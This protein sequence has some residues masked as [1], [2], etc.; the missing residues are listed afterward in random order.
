V[1][2][3]PEDWRIGVRRPS[4]VSNWK[5]LIEDLRGQFSY[6]PLTALIVETFANSVDAR[7]TKVD[8]FVEKDR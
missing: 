3:I 1:S 4:T 5:K 7:A 6:D 2:T 8:I